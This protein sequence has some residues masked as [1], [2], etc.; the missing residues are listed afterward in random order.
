MGGQD[1]ILSY[2]S[3]QSKSHHDQGRI[4]CMTDSGS[5]N[6]YNLC[7]AVEAAMSN[8]LAEC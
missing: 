2:L 6:A 7:H 5:K 4:Y 3:K 8:T 1:T